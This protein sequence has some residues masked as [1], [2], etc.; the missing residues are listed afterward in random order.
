MNFPVVIVGAGGHAKIA[1]DILSDNQKT[2]KGF[3]DPN[4]EHFFNLDRLTDESLNVSSVLLAMGLGG[5]T[6]ENLFKRLALFNAYRAKGAKFID[7]ISTNAFISKLAKMGAG[8]FINNG[9]V[10]N[11]PCKIA[12]LVIIN[13]RAIVEHDVVIE[14]GSHIAPGAVLLGGCHIGKNCMI[15]AGA[16]VLPGTTVPDN[17]LVPS[18]TRYSKN[19]D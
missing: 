18:L 9:A 17:S 4:V 1:F 3:I 8:I 12:D 6:P 14:A 2:L 5:M 13:T 16:V 15:G 19:H 10:I 11:G 7:I